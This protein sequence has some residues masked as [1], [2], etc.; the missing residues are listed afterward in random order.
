MHYAVYIISAWFCKISVNLNLIKN[1]K[2]LKKKN[3]L[4]IIYI[5]KVY[6]HKYIINNMPI[7]YVL[8]LSRNNK[9][10]TNI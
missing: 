5:L 3:C 9:I 2:L 4:N 7:I 10:Y 6:L 8:N 1:V